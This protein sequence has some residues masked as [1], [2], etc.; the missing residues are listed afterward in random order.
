MP[1]ETVSQPT[2]IEDLQPK[3][4]LEGEVTRTELYG[5]FVDLGLERDGMIHISRLAR[6]RVN[7]V[8]DKVNPGDKVTVWVENID[9]ERGRIALTMVEPAE[10]DWNELKAG[11]IRTGK[12][13]RLEPY[14]AF[15]DIGAERPGLLHVREMADRYVRHPSEIV[16]EGQEVEVRI[17]NVDRRK[18]QIDLSLNLGHAEAMQAIEDEEDP[19]LSPMEIAFRQAQKSSR[20]TRSKRRRHQRDDEDDLEDI[21]RRTLRR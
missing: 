19:F 10:V 6:R 15:V 21:Y 7:K 17:L 5:A 20:P 3:M 16:N 2:S 8:T 1:E 18:R 9:P 13:V 11:Q 4:K 12:V 14:G